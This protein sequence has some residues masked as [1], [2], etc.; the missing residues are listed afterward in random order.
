H[1]TVHSRTGGVFGQGNSPEDPIF[2]PHHCMVDYCWYDWNVN[3]GFDNPNDNEWM[4]TSW[5]HFVDVDGNQAEVTV[6]GTLLMPFL[7]YRYED[8]LLGTPTILQKSIRTKKEF[9]EVQE[10][11]K[12]GAP[13]NF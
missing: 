8:S 2:W 12:K 9:N 10:R 5:N 13:I 3:R 6:V 11:I 1:N 7:A 4:N